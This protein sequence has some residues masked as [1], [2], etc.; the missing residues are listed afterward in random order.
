ME[1]AFS[2]SKPICIA[3][4]YIKPTLCARPRMVRWILML[5]MLMNPD[6]KKGEEK[7]GYEGF[8]ETPLS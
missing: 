3:H 1:R 2:G 8:L 6:K 7:K 5:L 4:V